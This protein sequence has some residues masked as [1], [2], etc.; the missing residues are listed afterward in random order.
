MVSGRSAVKPGRPRFDEMADRALLKDT[1]PAE[2][3]W[4]PD[5]SIKVALSWWQA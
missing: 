2:F 1:D 5:G 3:E 4:M